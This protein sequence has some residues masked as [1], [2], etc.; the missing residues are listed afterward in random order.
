MNQAKLINNRF[1]KSLS[2]QSDLIKEFN[3]FLQSMIFYAQYYLGSTKRDLEE[4]E[5]IVKF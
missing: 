2:K 3:F 5:I 4:K 1:L